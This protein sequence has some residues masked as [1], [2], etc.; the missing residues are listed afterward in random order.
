MQPPYPEQACPSSQVPGGPA[1][2][3]GHSHTA[4]SLFP[5]S[6]GR[7]SGN[8][9]EGGAESWLPTK[10]L[11]PVPPAFFE[12]RCGHGTTFLLMEC[13]WEHQHLGLGPA[14]HV[15]RTLSPSGWLEPSLGGNS[16]VGM[17]TTR[18]PVGMEEQ[19]KG[20]NL[21]FCVHVWS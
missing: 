8:K 4:L 7:H 9:W 6:M 11:P 21:G 12:V 16:A 13:E 5:C 17:Q 18:K 3:R 2:S 15:V 10:S 14:S 1:A 20:R 19:H